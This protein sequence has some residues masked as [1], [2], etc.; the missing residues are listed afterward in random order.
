MGNTAL[1]VENIFINSWY[2][3]PIKVFEAD[4]LRPSQR[5]SWKFMHAILKSSGSQMVVPV[6]LGVLES[7]AGVQKNIGLP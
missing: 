3:A 4:L 7:M 6:P 1:L 2:Y 5:Y